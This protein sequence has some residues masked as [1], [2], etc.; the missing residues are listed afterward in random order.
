MEIALPIICIM[1]LFF[2]IMFFVENFPY[3]TW[4]FSAL[5]ILSSVGLVLLHTNPHSDEYWLTE[6][7]VEKS[8]VGCIYTIRREKEYYSNGSIIVNIKVTEPCSTI[9]D[10]INKNREKY[11]FNKIMTEKETK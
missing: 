8:S 3:G 1:S 11:T 5:L 10:I 6:S 9:Q 7:M 4:F 2:T